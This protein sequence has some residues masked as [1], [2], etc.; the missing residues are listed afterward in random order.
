MNSYL[1]KLPYGN[2]SS[3]FFITPQPNTYV[4]CFTFIE[5]S[6]AYHVHKF[7]KLMKF[8]LTYHPY[9]AFCELHLLIYQST[10]LVLP[11]IHLKYLISVLKYTYVHGT[12][13]SEIWSNSYLTTFINILR[14]IS[15]LFKTTLKCAHQYVQKYWLKDYMAPQFYMEIMGGHNQNPHHSQQTQSI[16][17]CI[18]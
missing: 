18:I 8:S 11:H 7:K 15:Q 9:I 5:S 2:S 6:F 4:G 16:D 13:L 12:T 10:C 14:G 1:T 3:S 17:I